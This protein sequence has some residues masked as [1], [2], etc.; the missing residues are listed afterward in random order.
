MVVDSS[1]VLAIVLE[2][3]EN[4]R[5]AAAINA[6]DARLISTVNLFEVLMVIESRKGPQW[7][8]NATALLNRWAIRHVSFDSEHV[9]EAQTAWRR[10]GKGRHP[11]GLSMGDCAAYATAILADQPLL[12]KGDDF[13]KTGIASVAWR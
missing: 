4:L 12:F 9:Y 10:F 8:T 7:V 11:A 6:D 5:L 2:E 1:A 3:P 13:T